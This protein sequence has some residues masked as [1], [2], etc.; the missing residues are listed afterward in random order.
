M[1]PLQEKKKIK[2]SSTSGY[3]IVRNPYPHYPSPNEKID[4]KNLYNIGQMWLRFEGSFKDG[5]KEGPGNIYLTNGHL[6]SGTFK[7]DLAEGRG[8]VFYQGKT[9]LKGIWRNNILVTKFE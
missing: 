8:G 4:F 7:K 5:N 6:F 3:G 1:S 9:L 2:E